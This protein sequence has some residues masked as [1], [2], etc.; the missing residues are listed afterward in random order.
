MAAQALR[1][2]SEFPPRVRVLLEC[3]LELMDAPVGQGELRVQIEDGRVRRWRLEAGW[4]GADTLARFDQN[5]LE[6]DA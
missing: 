2:V 1:D 5:R 3:A 6:P 4:Y